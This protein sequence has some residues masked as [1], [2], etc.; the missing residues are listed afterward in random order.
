MYVC[1][2][3]LPLTTVGSRLSHS[4]LQFLHLQSESNELHPV[5]L[6]AGFRDNIQYIKCLPQCLACNRCP[7]NGRHYHII[8]IPLYRVYVQESR[9]I[10]GI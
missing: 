10:N 2:P 9:N 7:I 6:A 4:Q 1:I 5:D 3:A 8:L